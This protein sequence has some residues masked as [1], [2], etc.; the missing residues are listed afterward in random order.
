MKEK[1]GI[2]KPEYLRF[3][4]VLFVLGLMNVFGNYSIIISLL[5]S[6]LSYVLVLYP[7]IKNKDVERS[8]IYFIACVAI[9]FDETIFVYGYDKEV[10]HFSFWGLPILGGYLAYFLSIIYF[11]VLYKKRGAASFRLSPEKRRLFNYILILLVTGTITIGFCMLVNDNNMMKTGYYPKHAISTILR[12]ICRSCIL[13]T[14]IILCTNEK[15]KD[16]C[17][18]YLQLI[19]IVVVFVSVVAALLGFTGFYADN[20]ILLAPL[21]FT[22]TP[23]L[24]IFSLKRLHSPF[25]VLSVVAAI[26]AIIFSFIYGGVAM[27][28]KWYLFILGAVVGIIFIVLRVKSIWTMIG[29]V[30][31]GLLLLP[32][33]AI[34]ISRISSENNYVGWKLTQAFNT[35]NIFGGGGV[36]DWYDSM[37][38]SPLFRIEEMQCILIEYYNKPAYILFGKGLSGTT[39]HYTDI[40]VW[41]E[42]DGGFPPEQQKLG[43]YSSMHESLLTI[44]LAHG[45][46]GM[47]FLLSMI[48]VLLRRAYFTPWAIIGTFWLFMFWDYNY[49][50]LVG[51]VAMALALCE[52]LPKMTEN[53]KFE[54]SK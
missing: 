34:P 16:L 42:G 32:L 10:G 21:S 53:V 2:F 19:L 47:V 25:R 36:N 15:W 52:N 44:I 26:L 35:I 12:F 14:A 20:K 11:I 43:A 8:F 24:L 54:I 6:L 33:L 28:S 30:I 40:L 7:V 9:T 50:M 49:S 18:D 38:L 46:F 4:V 48:R 39:R 29:Y 13:L 27:G 17:S 51:A 3:S 31:I 45:L 1:A 37:D 41:E 23:M 5:S 22:F